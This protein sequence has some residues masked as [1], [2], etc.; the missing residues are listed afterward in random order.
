[1]IDASWQIEEPMEIGKLNGR[2]LYVGGNEGIATIAESLEIIGLLEMLKQLLPSVLL[3]TEGSKKQYYK[4]EQ[5]GAYTWVWM[6]KPKPC[7]CT[8]EVANSGTLHHG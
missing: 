2:R 7:T 8:I 4:E 3:K 1:M 6:H 5:N